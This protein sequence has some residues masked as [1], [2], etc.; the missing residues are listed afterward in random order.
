MTAIE[1]EQII[2]LQ[3]L[4]DPP[5]WRSSHIRAELIKDSSYSGHCCWARSGWIPYSRNKPAQASNG[6]VKNTNSL[7][8]GVIA[9]IT[10]IKTLKSLTNTLFDQGQGSS[11]Y[12]PITE[13]DPQIIRS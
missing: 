8:Q 5:F 11:T 10:G 12:R 3:G 6:L 9:R 4:A 1:P 7:I 2:K 13:P